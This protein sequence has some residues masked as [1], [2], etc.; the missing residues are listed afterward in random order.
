MLDHDNGSG[1]ISRQLRQ[2]KLE[3]LW[4]SSGNADGDYLVRKSGGSRRFLR[5]G[6]NPGQHARF[7]LGFGRRLDLRNQFPG[8]FRH[9]RGSV[10]GFGNEVECAPPRGLHGGR[11][12][13]GAVGAEHNHRERMPSHDL[14]QRFDAVHA[15]HFQIERD[16][17]G[18][19]LFDF[20]QA[21]RAVHR[22]SDHFDRFVDGQHLRNQL[23]HEGR[24]VD[25]QNAYGAFLHAWPPAAGVKRGD[26]SG[27]I[28]EDT[29]ED[30]ANRM[31]S[32]EVSN[33]PELDSPVC[34]GRQRATCSTTAGKFKISTT[35]PS[36]RMEAPET[37]SVE[38][39]W[40][41]N[42]LIT[43]SSS[44]SR[45]STIN[46]YFLSPAVI[47]STKSLAFRSLSLSATRRPNRSNGKT[48]LR[49]C[50]TS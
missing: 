30:M 25:H 26:I 31:R 49:N 36:P 9:V 39:V 37:R 40:S 28:F 14:L 27:D 7:Q 23:A 16:H 5:L 46:P 32:V 22:G 50:S 21:E 19:Q 12:T 13:F 6:R 20:F 38:N 3:C 10:C 2:H 42:A 18:L 33:K 4:S 1:K 17:P 44:P 43:S 45:A 24:I 47:T 29:F 34:C 41:S 11:R 48:W 35:R 8:C 15:R